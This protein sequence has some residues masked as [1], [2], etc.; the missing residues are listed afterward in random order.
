[1]TVT[2]GTCWLSFV[3]IHDVLQGE[4]FDVLTV[5]M[6]FDV[7]LFSGVTARKPSCRLTTLDLRGIRISK[8]VNC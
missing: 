4:F 6:G 1:M 3:S 2:N 5:E 7:A 8:L